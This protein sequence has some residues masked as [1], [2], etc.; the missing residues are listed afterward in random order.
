MKNKVLI[1][2]ELERLNKTKMVKIENTDRT[3]IVFINDTFK[4][5][6]K[7]EEQGILN[8]FDDYSYKWLNSFFDNVIELINFNEFD[9]LDELE[10]SINDRIYEW[11]DNEVNVYTSDL[12]NW[13]SNG[14][15][16]T[17]FIDE[18]ASEGITQNILGVAQYKAIDE[19]F[20]NAS[21]CLMEYLRELF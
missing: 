20:N 11:T 18:V 19:L 2:K 1:L 9:D 14:Y 4:V 7:N 15:Q 21:N 5:F 13:V 8:P 12:K 16:T 3:R 10:E 6:G 17:F